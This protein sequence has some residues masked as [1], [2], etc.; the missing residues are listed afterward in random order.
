MKAVYLRGNDVVADERDG[1]DTG[2]PPPPQPGPARRDVGVLLRRAYQVPLDEPIPGDLR[3]L[4]DR[5]A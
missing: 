4:L 3:D 1:D 2:R 5:L